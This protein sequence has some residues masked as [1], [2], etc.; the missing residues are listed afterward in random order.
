M[1]GVAIIL[2]VLFFG[3]GRF[4]RSRLGGGLLV[5]V[6][7]VLGFLLADQRFAIGDGDLVVVGV[8]FGE[9]EE[10]VAVAAILDERRLQR[11]LNT[12]YLGKVDVAAQ[13]AAGL[14]FEIELFESVTVSDDNP[15]FFRVDTIHQHSLDSHSKVLRAIARRHRVTGEPV[16]LAW[17]H[18]RRI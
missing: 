11:R 5:V 3:T 10:A 13:L 17:R 14:G 9:G 1:A 12:R 18:A 15:R 2:V 16:L 8:D 7:L 6:V 4:G